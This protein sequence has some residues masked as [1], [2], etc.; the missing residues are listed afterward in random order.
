MSTPR[1]SRRQRGFTLLET[2]VT[3]VVV[4]LLM[5]ILMQALG[6]ALNLRTRMLRL[7]GEART[8]FL[9]EAWFRDA[10]GTAQADLDDGYG[11]MRG[12]RAALAHVSAAPLLAE[13]MSPVRWWLEPVAGGMALHYSDPAVPDMVVVPG[14]LQEARFAYLDRDG[15]WLE[16][17]APAADA[18]DRLPRLVR[19]EAR[20]ARGRLY[21]VVPMLGESLPENMLRPDEVFG[22]AM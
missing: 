20:T 12:D 18:R 21:W 9:Q 8:D 22:H 1:T 19:F 16:E 4:S 17:W 13:G 3:L 14:P 2:V 15:N 7:Q 5:A 11:A 10:I 6:N